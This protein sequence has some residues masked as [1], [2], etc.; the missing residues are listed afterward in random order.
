MPRITASPID[1][2]TA[3]AV[4]ERGLDDPRE[5][6]CPIVAALGD[7]PHAL[8]VA[9]HAETVAVVF[10]FMEPLGRG[11]DCGAPC[12]Q[13]KLKPH[14]PQDRRPILRILV[15]LLG[16]RLSDRP[17]Q[18]WQAAARAHRQYLP[19]RRATILRQC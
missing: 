16:Q 19:T 2:K 13:A 9:L 1:Y 7:Q 8:A 18:C 6:L 11:G 14:G 3:L 15:L 12:G 10:H 4:L 5:A 17:H